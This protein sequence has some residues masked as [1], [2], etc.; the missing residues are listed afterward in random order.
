MREKSR[1]AYSVKNTT[2]AMVSRILAL[3]MGYITRVVF[4]RCLNESYVS[5]NGLF[6]DILNV[7]ALSELGVGTAIIYALYKPVAEKDIEKQKSLMELY[8]KLYRIIAVMVT[9]MGLAVIPFLD[10][11]IKN[12]PDLEHMTLIYL[13]YLANSVLSYVSI[14]KRTLI[15][16]HQLGYIGVSCQTT[17]WMI[18]D[19]LQIVILLTTKNFF[20]YLIASILCT[21]GNNI[22]I[23]RKA[24]KLYPYLR[25]K[26][27][28]KLSREEKHGIFQNMKAMMMHKLGNVVL[29]NT[30]NLILSSIVG[31]VSVGCYSNYNLIILSVKQVL[32][33]TFHG[34]TA[35]V[36]NLGVQKDSSYI[37]KIFET[38]FFLGQWMYG[39]AAICLYEL[40]SL[41]VEISFGKQ[42]VF[43]NDVVFVLCLNFFV[44]GMRQATLIF[45]D[46]LGL[47][48]YDRYKS[49]AEAVLNLIISIVLAKRLGTF[50]VFAGTFL[51][52][53][54]ISFWIEPYI[55][56][57]YGLKEKI[58]NYF[59]KYG[60]YTAVICLAGIVTHLLCQNISGSVMKVFLMRLPICILVPNL[61]FSLAYFK[62]REMKL[63]KEKLESIVF[64]KHE[65]K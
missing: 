30:D 9:V 44:T 25:D 38:S 29:N 47:F 13:L 64:R 12:K 11:L 40:L 37:R 22:T 63:M 1:T 50:G 6:W 3:V 42:Y 33:Q 58:K 43:Q 53:M 39:F 14:Y 65:E 31:I 24:D 36:G 55:L 34:I 61:L 35:S 18:Q 21:V 27:V 28:Q 19:V 45:R 17:F 62:T 49:I 41:F 60:C 26:E 46:S 16:A 8:H 10:V 23:S 54:L 5:I 57:K 48:R 20:L 51:S 52:T 4:T 2:T 15:D 56:Y 7:L 32:D 59:L